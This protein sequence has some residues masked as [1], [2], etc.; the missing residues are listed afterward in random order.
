ME[1][2]ARTGEG[3]VKAAIALGYGAR[4]WV[5]KMPPNK[6]ILKKVPFWRGLY[7]RLGQILAVLIAMVLN[8]RRKI[9]CAGRK[10]KLFLP[11]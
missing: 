11:G 9:T 10:R 8:L 3:D 4:C 7:L 6:V 1:R 2:L 5:A